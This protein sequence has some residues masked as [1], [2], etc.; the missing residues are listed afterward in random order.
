MKLVDMERG[1]YGTT[2]WLEIVVQYWSYKD[3][4]DYSQFPGGE[5][6]WVLLCIEMGNINGVTYG[7]SYELVDQVRV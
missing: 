4:E 2:V 1:M 7:I 3:I 5:R 6:T